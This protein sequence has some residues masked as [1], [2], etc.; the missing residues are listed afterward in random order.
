MRV[1]GGSPPDG[2]ILPQWAL[3]R[4]KIFELYKLKIFELYNSTRR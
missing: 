4:L 3:A 1:H 2:Q